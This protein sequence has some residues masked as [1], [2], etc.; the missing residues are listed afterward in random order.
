MEMNLATA[1]CELDSSP[2]M[3]DSQCILQDC[4]EEVLGAFYEEVVDVQRVAF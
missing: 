4:F 3:F 2:V 1:R